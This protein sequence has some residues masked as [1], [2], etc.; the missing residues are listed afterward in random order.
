MGRQYSTKETLDIANETRQRLQYW[1][2]NGI[3][4]PYDPSSGTGTTRHYS[5]ENILEIL[6][7]KRLSD[8]RIDVKIIA[9]V[10]KQVKRDN[11]DYF[12]KF[13]FEKEQ[14]K[15]LILGVE[16]LNVTTTFSVVTA[17][18]E[19]QEKLNGMLKEDNVLILLNLD[20]LKSN[21]LKKLEEYS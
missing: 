1:I 9:N 13:H 10:L 11:R 14:N 21:L 3:V 19:I 16:I 5:L 18:K 17:F 4:S 20:I 6:I 2:L 8:S 15:Q 12:K 7:A